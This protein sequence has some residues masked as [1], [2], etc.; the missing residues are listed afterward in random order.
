[1]RIT[2]ITL[3]PE[4]ISGF[5]SCSILKRASDKGLVSFDLLNLR[6]FAS[7]NNK[8]IV[9]DMSYGGGAGMVLKPEPLFRAVEYVKSIIDGD[10]LTVLM[11]PQGVPLDQAKVKS[12]IDEKNLIIICGHYE[13]IDERVR[14]YLVDVELSVGDYILT[15]GEI[16]AVLFSD[17]LVR[18]L[19]GVLGNNS[20]HEEES[21]YDG[22]LEYPHYTRPY[23]Y[24][25]M[26]VPE[27]LLSGNHKDISR[28]RRMESLKRTLLRRP[29]MLS[30]LSLSKE[31]QAYCAMLKK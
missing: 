16:P 10:V 21:F 13:G 15:G 26:C 17:A 30:K 5:L 25:G 27:V 22:T 18:L 6:D 29:D 11:T 4:A 8:K 9:D 14:E 28:W 1:M 20:S 23:E 2:I 19:P 12:F 7:G 3:F 24:R 31:E